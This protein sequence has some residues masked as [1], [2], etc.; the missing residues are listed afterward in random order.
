MERKEFL[1]SIG[2]AAALAVTFSCLG[3]CSDA[4]PE[5]APDATPT[6][7]LLTLDLTAASSE[8]LKESGGY[9]IKNNIVVAKNLS[10]NYVAA[11]VVCSHQ[12]NKNVIFREDEF[13]CTAHGA[14]FDLNGN[15]LNDEG[16]NGLKIYSTSVEGDLLIISN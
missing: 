6:G 12:Q 14:R 5:D 15:G 11:T 3:G 16:G 7:T 9:L 1:K 10:G 2:A 13:Y 4:S 8:P